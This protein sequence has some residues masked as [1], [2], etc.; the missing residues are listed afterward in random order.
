MYKRHS[1]YLVGHHRLKN[2]VGNEHAFLS[3]LQ[4]G[5]QTSATAQRAAEGV[6]RAGAQ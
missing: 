5:A 3:V 1:G 6:P 2:F 4:A